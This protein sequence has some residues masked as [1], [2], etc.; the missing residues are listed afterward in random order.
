[1]SQQ[2]FGVLV[3][4]SEL[5]LHLAFLLAAFILVATPVHHYYSTGAFQTGGGGF[6][7]TNGYGSGVALYR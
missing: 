4:L 5:A 7:C 3:A 6:D 1:V 2:G